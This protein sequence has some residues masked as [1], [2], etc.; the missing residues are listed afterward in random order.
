M[1]KNPFMN[2]ESSWS[3]ILHFWSN[4]C[5]F[6]MDESTLTRAVF[7]NKI[8]KDQTWNVIFSDHFL[9]S[10]WW[11][12][13]LKKFTNQSRSQDALTP[14]GKIRANKNFV[15]LDWYIFGVFCFNWWNERFE[16]M[17]TMSIW[18]LPFCF[19]IVRDAGC[20]HSQIVCWSWIVL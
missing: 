16:S 15:D 7:V 3:D 6:I 4:I 20:F 14:F 17:I 11:I 2:R 10:L 1:Q 19:Y 12:P 9:S 13:F 18:I 8:I 5:I